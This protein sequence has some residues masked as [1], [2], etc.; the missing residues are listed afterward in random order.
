MAAEKCDAEK[1]GIYDRIGREQEHEAGK[2]P[3]EGRVSAAMHVSPL[4]L[5]ERRSLRPSPR[6]WEGFM[7]RNLRRDDSSAN[8]SGRKAPPTALT[9][10]RHEGRRKRRPSSLWAGPR[11]THASPPSRA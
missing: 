3:E 6:L 1:T 9:A 11:L 4:E 5:S 2:R 8:L 10:R 7:P